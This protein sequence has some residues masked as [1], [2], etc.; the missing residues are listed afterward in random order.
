MLP[1]AKG[2][3]LTFGSCVHKALEDT[4]DHFMKKGKFPDFK[5]FRESFT[6]EV[7]G[8]GVESSIKSLCMI[9]IEGVKKWFDRE[10][11]AP[12]KPIGLEEKLMAIL[13]DDL[14][15]TGKYDKT[16]LVSEKEKSVRVVDYKTGKPDDHVKDIINGLKDGVEL[17]SDECDGY[18]RQ[19][20]AYKLLFER[21]KRRKEGYKVTKGKLVFVEPAK[22]NAIYADLKI[23][24]Y[25]DL[26]VELTDDMVVELESVIKDVRRRV[27]KLD[28][29]KL[30]ERD[31]KKCGWC[32]FDD[33]CWG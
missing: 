6:R 8:E 24:E 23:G 7:E 22:T 11:K 16:E 5:F 25:R 3:S 14:V 12:V 13:G 17:A 31:E 18:L 4:Y 21:D 32:D 20:V 30:P 9:G 19:L 27:K 29:K 2:F 26:D 33:I 28:F 15:F 10:S 1:G